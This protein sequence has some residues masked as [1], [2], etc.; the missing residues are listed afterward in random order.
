MPK[1]KVTTRATTGS[2]QSSVE[3]AL[4]GLLDEVRGLKTAAVGRLQAQA[5]RDRFEMYGSLWKL[6]P[7]HLEAVRL[8]LT[9]FVDEDEVAEWAAA[10][11]EKL[12]QVFATTRAYEYLYYSE[13][14]RQLFGKMVGIVFV[15]RLW[16]RELGV[17]EH[18][19]LVHLRQGRYYPDFAALV[20]LVLMEGADF[21]EAEIRQAGE[22][23]PK[24]RVEPAVARALHASWEQQLGEARF[25]RETACF[26]AVEALY[27]DY[28]QRAIEPK[29]KEQL[30]GEFA[31]LGVP[32]VP[33]SR[34]VFRRLLRSRTDFLLAEIARRGAKVPRYS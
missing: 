4:E 29:V 15:I 31:E 5:V 20:N 16:I 21:V 32:Y 1:A 25:M 27:Y 19:R 26:Q 23:A 30:A 6:T 33:V 2:Q 9:E 8:S 34:A 17:T 22:A 14:W 13:L 7:E 11:E 3:R 28:M 18:F 12:R 24:L 10:P